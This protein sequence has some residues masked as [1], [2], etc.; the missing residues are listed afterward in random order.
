RAD[1]LILCC[2]G[3]SA[4][5]DDVAGDG[6]VVTRARREAAHAARRRRRRPWIQRSDR[7]GRRRHRSPR[8]TRRTGRVVLEDVVGDDAVREGGAALVGHLERDLAHTVRV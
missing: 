3:L 2:D 7:A 6:Y 1:L 5:T 8:S 4:T